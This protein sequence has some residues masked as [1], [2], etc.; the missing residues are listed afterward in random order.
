MSGDKTNDN[1]KATD[2]DAA[3]QDKGVRSTSEKPNGSLPQSVTENTRQGRDLDGHKR[4]GKGIV[5]EH[6]DSESSDQGLCFDDII[7]PGGE[8]SILEPSITW[9]SRTYGLSSSVKMSQL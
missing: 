7:S 3:Q 6:S 9:K 8:T 1:G 2:E 5:T 4:K